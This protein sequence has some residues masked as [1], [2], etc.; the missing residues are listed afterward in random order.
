M[1]VRYCMYVEDPGAFL[2]I[3]YQ[4]VVVLELM[5][6]TTVCDGVTELQCHSMC[7]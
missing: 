2:T 1:C 7:K 4:H 3:S 6:K 5:L